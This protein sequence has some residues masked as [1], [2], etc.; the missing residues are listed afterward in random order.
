M[1]FYLYISLES[2][3]PHRIRPKERDGGP[4]PSFK[5]DVVPSLGITLKAWNYHA[6]EDGTSDHSAYCA[7]SG[8]WLGH[9]QYLGL[10]LNGV[11]SENA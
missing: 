7:I 9:I 2:E 6:V 3:L 11:L 5:A 8:E 10:L 4:E 1:P